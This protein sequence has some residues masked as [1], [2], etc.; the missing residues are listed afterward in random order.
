MNLESICPS[1]H[2]VQ[3]P[4]CTWLRQPK[5]HHHMQVAEGLFGLSPLLSW[6]SP[7]V[8]TLEHFVS[9]DSLDGLHAEVRMATRQR[10]NVWVEQAERTLKNRYI[11]KSIEIYTYTYTNYIYVT[12]TYIQCTWVVWWNFLSHSLAPCRSEMS[13]S[14][15]FRGEESFNLD[16]GEFGIRSKGKKSHGD[17]E[18]NPNDMVV[19]QNHPK[20]NQS[21]RFENWI[22]LNGPRTDKFC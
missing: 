14:V 11:K 7:E 9:N 8:G 1:K 5:K 15:D 13:V 12:Y 18:T 17:F 6:G 3:K 2:D 4:L 10:E 22:F 19:A 16:F 21:Q 20:W